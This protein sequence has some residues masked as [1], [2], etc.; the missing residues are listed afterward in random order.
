MSKVTIQILGTTAGV[1]TRE[2]SHTSIYLTHDDGEQVP[3]LFD[4]GEGTQ[5]QMLKAG[6]NMMRI[7]NI[8]IT[9]W[10]GDHCLGLPGLVDTLGFE[11]RKRPLAIYAPEIRRL[12][13][14]IGLNYPMGRFKLKGRNVRA[15]GKKCKEV[16]KTDRFS[17]L[18]IPVKHSIPTVAYSLLEKDKV[19]ID[20]RKAISLGLPEKGEFYSKLK[21]KGKVKIG[22][23]TVR[24][25]DISYRRKG[26][27]IAYSGDT[28]ICDNLRNIV[29]EADLLI[30]DCTYF[31]DSGPLKRHRHASMPEVV[32]MVSEEGVKMTI[33][34]H[35]SRKYQND[36]EL[37]GMIK[38][39]PDIHLAEDFMT[40][41]I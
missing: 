17:I 5:R 28:E 12:K 33:L 40:V 39:F 38:D 30:M 2:R 1:P 20:M 16:F 21:E 32:R 25:E 27:K 31:E 4:C 3:I 11:G 15:R 24:L 19:S 8:F 14:C 6:I 7:D 37:R 26:K 18:S 34:T 13:K 22:G 35:I 10:H 36:E 9:H 41:T 29:R 23:K